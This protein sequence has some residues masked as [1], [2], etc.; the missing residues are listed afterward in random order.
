MSLRVPAVAPGTVL[1]AL[2]VDGPAL[3]HALLTHTLSL[4]AA[5]VRF[6]VILV[7]MHLCWSLVRAIVDHYA[8]RNDELIRQSL[9]AGPDTTVLDASD[10]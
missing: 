2:V 7:A 5:I 1:L 4:Q 8:E 3:D 6:L 10:R 9:P